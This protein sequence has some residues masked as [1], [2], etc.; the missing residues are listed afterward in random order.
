MSDKPKMNLSE[1][2]S[3]ILRDICFARMKVLKAGETGS[4]DDLPRQKELTEFTVRQSL[5]VFD[6]FRSA[7]AGNVEAVKRQSAVQQSMGPH[8]GGGY[9]DGM[10][11]DYQNIMAALMLQGSYTEED[12]QRLHSRVQ[13]FIKSLKTGPARTLYIADCHFYH[14]RICREMD[15]RGF[16]G[17]EEMNEH[18]IAQWNARVTSRDD[19]YILGD[20]CITRGDAAE[21]IL[22]RLN[23]KLHLIIGNHDKYLED[24]RFEAW[25][26]FRSVEHY[27]EI[28]D[29]GR[30]VILSHYPVFCYKGQ[31]RRDK[32]GRPL[33]YMLYGHVHNTHDEVLINRFIMETRATLAKS[34]HA[35]QPEP[36]PCNMINCFCMFSNYQPLT[37]DEWIVTDR[38]RRAGM[39]AI[40]TADEINTGV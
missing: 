29:N 12:V 10:I 1:Q 31:Y 19:V 5:P 17:F 39:P 21:R 2:N 14:D 37:L 36:I 32:E 7:M 4:A 6:F 13:G 40:G 9:Y 8:A 34:R 25:H 33:T 11:A 28:R 15:N 26:W 35:D 27:Q 20:F 22:D 38:K 24:K 30:T 18:M 23:G 16:S 3:T